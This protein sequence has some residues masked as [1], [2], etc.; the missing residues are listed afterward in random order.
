[1]CCV[2]INF[3]RNYI[4]NRAERLE[5]LFRLTKKGVPW[6]WGIEQIKAFEDT[7]AAVGEAVLLTYSRPNKEFII[8]LDASDY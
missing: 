7:K 1:M 5:P 8:Y 2:M 4:K 3:I 6:I